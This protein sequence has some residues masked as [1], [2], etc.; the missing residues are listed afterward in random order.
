MSRKQ[1]RIELQE[2]WHSRSM[3]VMEF[4]DNEEGTI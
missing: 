3:D 1:K 4:G 2:K